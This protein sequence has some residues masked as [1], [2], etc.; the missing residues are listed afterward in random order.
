MG[1]GLRGINVGLG[2]IGFKSKV[3]VRSHSD[4]RMPFE[5]HIWQSLAEHRMGAWS[6]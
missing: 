1:L 3:A 5:H 6:V 4:P 2:L